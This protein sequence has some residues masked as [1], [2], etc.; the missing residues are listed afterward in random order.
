MHQII[1]LE[2]LI[3]GVYMKL[4]AMAVKEV[5][6]YIKRL[7]EFDPILN[8]IFVVGELSN[9]KRHSSGHLY[10]TLKDSDAKI[11]CVMFRSSASRMN[12]QPKDG[13]K[14]EIRG[15]IGL[16]EKEGRY[17]IYVDKMSPIGAGELY[18]AFIQL[19]DE[20]EYKGYFNKGQAL[21]PLPNK[22]GIVSSPTGAAIRDMLKVLRRRNPLVEIIIYPARV[23]GQFSAFEIANGIDFFNENPVDT[24]IIGRGGGSLEELWSFNEL[25]VAEAI[26]ASKIPVISAVG[27]ETDFTIADFVADLRAATP[28]E[29]AELAVISMEQYENRVYDLMRLLKT[30]IHNYK[31]KYDLSLEQ[32][33]E[34]VLCKLIRENM[35]GSHEVLDHSLVDARNAIKQ[36]LDQ[37]SKVLDYLGALLNSVSP[38]NTLSRGYAIA[39]N[40]KGTI[41]SIDSVDIADR[42]DIL[43]KNGIIKTEVIS[44]ER[45]E[46]TNE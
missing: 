9:F 23:Q 14:V 1:V 31:T 32:V 38:L 24:I 19:K 17:Q 44:K 12:F 46:M 6:D 39:R 45:K 29:A 36:G 18:Q 10:F 3:M 42:I 11:S 27:H 21:K 16:Y 43:V 8:Q 35:V 40:E 22:I 25:M 20:L 33:N 15:R 30:H 2:M 34:E 13:Q 28:T 4:R 41:T 26:Y 5:N 37:S 7:L